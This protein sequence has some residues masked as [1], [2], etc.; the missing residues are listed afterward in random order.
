MSHESMCRYSD[1]ENDDRL[2]GGP[3][4][5]QRLGAVDVHVHYLPPRYRRLVLDAGIRKPDG[6]HLGVPEWSA[7][8]H[9]A[10]ME[11][12]GIETSV[13]SISTP[14]VQFT[15][16]LADG[17]VAAR[18]AN[19]E[20]AE[21]VAAHPGRFGFYAALPV[22][23][24]DA[25]LVE[26]ERAADDLGAWGVSL[27]TNVNGVYIGDPSLEPLYAELSRRELP[28]LIH[29]TQPS[30]TVPGVM[31]GWSKSMYEYF[32]DSTRAIIDLIFSGM[33]ERHP[34][35]RLVVPHAGAA[36]PALAQR[37]ER[38]VW[39]ANREGDGPLPS[40]IDT[41]RRCYF[42]LAGS[43]LPHQ[44]PSLLSLVDD[45][46]ILYGSD[47][48]FTSDPM[49]AELAADLRSTTLLDS[50]QKTRILRTN[51]GG[52]FRQLGAEAAS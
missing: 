12:L 4:S 31:E 1:A 23:D 36:L 29:P 7:D 26:L 16:D 21:L 25:A 2:D 27:M 44:L 15:D 17:V 45:D 49:G 48:P 11:R 5:R 39:R 38:N 8:A 24:V 14:G 37:I 34:G 40:F 35:V 22:P 19:E 18:T 41:L 3:A 50:E 32:F 28:L 51:A 52:L 43:V 42:D 33:L 10:H 20:G 9:L 6:Y 13:V 47:Y 46:R 30:A